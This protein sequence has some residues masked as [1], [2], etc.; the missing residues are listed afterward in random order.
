MALLGCL[1]TQKLYI[2]FL[3]TTHQPDKPIRANQLD[4]RFSATEKNMM[5]TALTSEKK[6]T[7]DKYLR[8][9]VSV[10]AGVWFGPVA[11]STYAQA[12]EPIQIAKLLSS[13][14]VA[15]QQFGA[16]VS[17]SGDT[18]VIGAYLDEDNGW[19]S[20]AAYIYTRSGG[21]WTQIAK[22]IPSDGAEGDYFGWSV[23]ISGATVVIGAYQHDDNGTNSGAAYIYTR[24]GEVWSE[25]AK[26]LPAGGT[27]FDRFGDSVSIC[28]DTV[29]IGAAENGVGTGSA[30]VFTRSG[31]VWSQQAKILPGDGA[32][33]DW[34]GI[35]VTISDDTAVIGAFRDD[36]NGTNS[37]SAYVYLRNDGIWTQQAKLLA[38]DGT[39]GD[40]FG[41]S[42]SI[43]GDTAV[44]GASGDDEN[45]E[46]SGSA[47]V[48]VYSAG[49][50]T[51]QTKLLLAKGT[52][53]D[54]FGDSVSIDG[55]TAIIGTLGDDSGFGSAYVFTSGNGVWTQQAKLQAA[56]GAVLDYFGFSVS[57]SGD[58][59]IIGSWLDDD[60]GSDSGS[61]YIFNLGCNGC[62][63]DLNSDDQ[64]DF[65]DLQIFLNWY[66]SGDLQADFTVDGIL[67]FFDV[68]EYLNLYSAGCS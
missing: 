24:S 13:D 33:A 48:F 12:C 57:V 53:F 11:T 43:N 38:D 66:A 14:G 25:Q 42:V 46:I 56:D 58:T 55:N 30:Y 29:V 47:Y 16:S 60:N 44:I 19:G 18:A 59:A 8:V 49:T 9:L 62:L 23:A 3:G 5:R 27:S 64:L 15:G 26:L 67:D 50:W 34:F 65:F 52:G 41:I 54:N 40:R 39:E 4:S 35:S 7:N 63:A 31:S 21:N 20:G 32:A 28:G 37:G 51:Q 1:K 6:L 36:D 68:Q 10:M 22:L 17:V 61:A 45:G 2:G